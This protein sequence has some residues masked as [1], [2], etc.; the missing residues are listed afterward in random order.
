MPSFVVAFGVDDR[1]FHL[2]P[3]RHVQHGEELR[4]N[5]RVLKVCE[6]FAKDFLGGVDMGFKPEDC[7]NPMHWKLKG[8]KYDDLKP[9][10]Q[11]T[12]RAYME[13]RSQIMRMA[14]LLWFGR[15]GVLP[16]VC[17]LHHGNAVLARLWSLDHNLEWAPAV[18]FLQLAA[19]CL[20]CSPFR[21]QQS[22]GL[23]C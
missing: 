2:H 6:G 11:S 5:V 23:Q 16:E 19:P 17:Q 10:Q 18:N 1:V 22:H 7:R 20:T 8:I 21:L 12:Y 3:C 13:A 4:D 9:Y 14:T 15:S